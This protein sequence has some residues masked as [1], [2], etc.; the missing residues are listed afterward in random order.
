MLDTNTASYII[1]GYPEQVIT[2]LKKVPMASICISAIT[3]AELLHGVAKKPNAKH[4]PLIVNEFL[5]RVDVLPWDSKAAKTYAHL[6]TACEKEGKSLST[7]DML[8]A[9]HSVAAGTVLITSDRAFYKVAHLLALQDW[10]KPKVKHTDYY[11]RA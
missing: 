1:K 3:E 7:M 9:A 4:L 5:L 8:I 2:N 10:T 11:D 6:R